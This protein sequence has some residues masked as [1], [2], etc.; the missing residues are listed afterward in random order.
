[1]QPSN[2]VSDMI[3][4]SLRMAGLSGIFGILLTLVCIWLSWRALGALRLDPFLKDPKS[5]QARLLLV[6]VSVAL[7]HLIA[8]FVLDY[9]SWST[10]IRLLF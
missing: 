9:L 6:L 10:Q 2:A 1:M 4:S 8:D 3:D 7:G 5:G